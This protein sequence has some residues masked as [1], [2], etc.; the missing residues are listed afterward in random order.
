MSECRRCQELHKAHERLSL[1]LFV[2]SLQEEESED[3]SIDVREKI[4]TSSSEKAKKF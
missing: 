1:Y 4:E 3:R 2:H